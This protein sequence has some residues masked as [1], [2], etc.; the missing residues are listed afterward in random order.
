MNKK[1][2]MLLVLIMCLTCLTGCDLSAKELDAITDRLKSEGIIGV[3][4]TLVY[5]WADIADAIPTITAYNYHYEGSNYNYLITIS[6]IDD[7][8]RYQ[9]N[10]Y[11]NVLV[12]EERTPSTVADNVYISYD[13]DVAMSTNTKESTVELEVKEFKLLGLTLMKRLAI[14]KVS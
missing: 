6:E 12:T 5:E 10:K 8:E 7:N 1:R 14:S 13:F 2:N 11:E 3:S 9:V 4:D